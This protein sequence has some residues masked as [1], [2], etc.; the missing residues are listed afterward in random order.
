MVVIAAV[1]AVVTVVGHRQPFR[2]FCLALRIGVTGI[3]K[4]F[5]EAEV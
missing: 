3:L 4:S 2:L 1:I 5:F